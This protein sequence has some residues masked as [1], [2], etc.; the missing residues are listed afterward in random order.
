MSC[1][2]TDSPKG[3]GALSNWEKTLAIARFP[4][5]GYGP[6]DLPIEPSLC[7]RAL[8]ASDQVCSVKKN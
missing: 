7:A 1:L 6:A 5:Y 2:K 8:K 3:K 4:G